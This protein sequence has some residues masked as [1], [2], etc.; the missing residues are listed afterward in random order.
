MAE[1]G[2]AMNAVRC[3]AAL[4]PQEQMDEEFEMGIAIKEQIIPR[5]LLW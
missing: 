5:A 1:P 3:A 4:G 2:A